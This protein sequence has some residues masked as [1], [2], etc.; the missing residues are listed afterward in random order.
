MSNK[1]LTSIFYNVESQKQSNSRGQSKGTIRQP[2][3]TLK[4]QNLVIGVD[5]V[6]SDGVPVTDLLTL[7]D[8]FSFTADNDFATGTPL[9]LLSTDSEFNIVGDRPD[10]DVVNGKISFRIDAATLDLETLLGTED[11]KEL[12]GE[13]KIFDAATTN[14][15]AVFRLTITANN[16]VDNSGAGPSPSPVALFFTKIEVIALLAG[17]EDLGSGQS[18]TIDFTVSGT[19]D[20]FTVLVDTVYRLEDVGDRTDSISGSG[21][22]HT[23]KVKTS[24][25][26]LTSVLTSH[27][28]A[29][30]EFTRIVTTHDVLLLAGTIVQYEVIDPSTFTTHTGRGMIGG[31]S[32][33]A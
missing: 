25:G 33:A 4:Q 10:L 1:L 21:S 7:T 9:K 5:F 3:V 13:I 26:D 19:T 14:P 23:F 30:N 31:R 22:P 32:F 15:K 12:T 28:T 24:A 27:A 16:L 8:T 17:K 29:V 11:F 2:I 18:T 20:I 6:D